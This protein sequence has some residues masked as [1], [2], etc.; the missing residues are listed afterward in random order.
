MRP[1][2]QRARNGIL[3]ATECYRILFHVFHDNDLLRSKDSEAVGITL[4][5]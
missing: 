2:L 3:P 5:N 4:R 1:D